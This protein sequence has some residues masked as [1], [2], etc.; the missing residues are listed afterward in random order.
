MLL[1]LLTQRAERGG[2][3]GLSAVKGGGASQ[4]ALVQ[5][6]T[7]SLPPRQPSLFLSAMDFDEQEEKDGE[8][9]VHLGVQ[10]HGGDEGR[11]REL[12]GPI[13][14]PS[15]LASPFCRNSILVEHMAFVEDR[16]YQDSRPHV[17]F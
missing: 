10:D 1:C 6:Q 9:F 8:H 12:T 2:D 4:R 16:G 15:P 5:L 13:S 17:R 14:L 7:T 11:A 3:A